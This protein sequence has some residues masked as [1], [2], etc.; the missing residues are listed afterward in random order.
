MDIEKIDENT[1]LVSPKEV[2]V[3]VLSLTLPVE[4][5]NKTKELSRSIIL[6]KLME[7]SQGY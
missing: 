1:F 6:E 5:L 4:V 7:A 3:G 2:R